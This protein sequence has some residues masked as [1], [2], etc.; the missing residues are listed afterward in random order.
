MPVYENRQEFLSYSTVSLLAS[1]PHLH[2]EIEM[3]YVFD[4][5]VQAI[6][7]HRS[8]ELKEGDLFITFPHQIHYYLN[9]AIGQYALLIHS[10]K[11]FFGLENLI[12]T[13]EPSENV[14]HI[15]PGSL[16]DNC[17]QKIA[18]LDGEYR[19]TE[20]S[21]YAN[22]IMAQVLPELS[23]KPIIKTSNATVKNILEYCSNHYMENISLDVIAKDLHLNKYYISHVINKHTNMSLNSFIN[24]LRINTACDMLRETDKKIADISE[25]VGFG[26]IRTFNRIFLKFMK[27]TPKEYREKMK[28][29]EI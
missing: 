26:A 23:L 15:T 5:N 27:I 9:T 3:I 13:N 4:G 8:F 22:L 16:V 11:I 25:E 29:K 17:F 21:A 18:N 6:A 2:K 19:E 10:P 28:I 14:V 24:C 20:I 1:L 7:N 12:N